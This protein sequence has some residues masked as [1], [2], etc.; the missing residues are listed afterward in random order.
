MVRDYIERS[1]LII[2]DSN[3]LHRYLFV[4]GVTRYSIE[5]AI[6]HFNQSIT[7]SQSL[8]LEDLTN[9]LLKKR[10]GYQDYLIRIDLVI[11]KAKVKFTKQ[12]ELKPF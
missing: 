9:L 1:E 12:K 7:I 6:N 11:Q 8:R 2:T 5:K 10:E 3:I 4:A